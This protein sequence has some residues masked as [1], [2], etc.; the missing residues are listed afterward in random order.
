MLAEHSKRPVMG[1]VLYL[2][3]GISVTAVSGPIIANLVQQPFLL[4]QTESGFSL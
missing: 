1:V 2:S 3:G 4:A